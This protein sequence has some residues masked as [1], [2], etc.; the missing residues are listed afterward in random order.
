M[1]L[2]LTAAIVLALAFL[3]SM[4]GLGGAMLYIPVFHWFGYDFKS[5]AIPTGLLLNGV[6]ALSAAVSYLRAGMVDVRGAAPLIVSSFLGA[7]VGALFTRYV[8]TETL[9][10]LFAA[11]MILAG[12]RML[13][14]AGRPDTRRHMAPGARFALMGAGGFGVGMIAGLLGIGGGFL[15][16]P[17]MLAMGYPTKQ[18]A[19]TSAFVVVFS[20]FSGFAGHLAEGHFDWPLMGATLAAVIVGSQLGAKVMRERMKAAWIKRMFGGVLLAVAA[21]LLWRLFG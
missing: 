8:P 10:L 18:A 6:T 4:L 11:G 13:I 9:I 14:A 19:A 2:S 15:F 7:P 12:G 5:V 3:F 16:V 1:M 17:M 21:K 20:S